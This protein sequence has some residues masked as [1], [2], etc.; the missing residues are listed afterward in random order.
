MTQ[1]EKIKE[2]EKKEIKKS[3]IVN[4]T[5]ERIDLPE[6]VPDLFG[7]IDDIKKFIEDR[8]FKI[9]RTTTEYH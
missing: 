7:N 1:E 8:K 6:S 4:I 9:I 2:E 3:L 5:V